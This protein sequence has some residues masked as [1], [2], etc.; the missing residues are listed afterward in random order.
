MS[1]LRRLANLF[2]SKIFRGQFFSFFTLIV[3]SAAIF[4]LTIGMKTGVEFISRQAEIAARYHDQLEASLR[5]WLDRQTAAVAAFSAIMAESD[6]ATLETPEISD[7]I[8]KIVNNYPDFVDFLIVDDAGILVNSRTHVPRDRTVFLG[9]RDYVQTAFAEGLGITGF[10]IG[11]NTGKLAMTVASRFV[12]KDGKAYVGAAFITLD[13]FE[14]VLDTLNQGGVG[15]AYLVD[16]DG[17]RLTGSEDTSAPTKA[18][19][20]SKSPRVVNPA[21]EAASRGERGFKQYDTAAGQVLAAHSMIPRLNVGLVVEIRKELFMGPLERLQR[22]VLLIGLAGVVLA[23][24]AAFIL[25]SQIFRPIEEL[26][27]AVDGIAESDYSR[28]IE[29]STGNELDALIDRFNRMQRLIA[30]RE[31]TLK[32]DASRD[33][34]TGLYNH[35]EVMSYLARAASKPRLEETCFAMIDIDHFKRINDQYGHQ[36][37]DAVLVALAGLLKASVRADDLVGRYGGEEF[38]IVLREKTDVDN[39]SFCERLRER[40]EQMEFVYEGVRIPVTASVGWACAE[41]DRI[42][43]PDALVGAADAALYRA[44]ANGRNRTER[45][46]LDEPR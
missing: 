21:A 34:L 36:A 3:G 5:E 17:I 4:T 41:S 32:D 22:F 20:A 14:I 2:G 39:E 31:T 1:P 11:R 28:S 19:D 7:R 25:S 18:A 13:R 40:I 37:G 9:D 24:V 43:A 10:T 29:L 45:G 35:G 8:R 42:F 12:S 6:S 26:I 23:A 38:A 44:K 15:S 16:L 33:S 27:R 46:V 30:E